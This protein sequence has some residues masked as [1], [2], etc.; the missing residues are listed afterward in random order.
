MTY[1]NIKSVKACLQAA[2]W[3]FDVADV[4]E[5]T[6]GQDAVMNQYPK[7]GTEIDPKNPESIQLQV[8]TGDPATG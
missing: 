3:Q 4:D 2:G 1:K 7:A 8:S 6:F 5:N